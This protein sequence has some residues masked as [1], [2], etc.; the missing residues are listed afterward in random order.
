MPAMRCASLSLLALSLL[1]SGPALA[2]DTPELRASYNLY[3]AGF[4][5][6]D[7]DA[8]FGVGPHSYQLRLAY[9]TTGVISLFHYGHQLNTVVGT[10]EGGRPEP[11]EFQAVGVWQ[12]EDKVTLI[13]YL[14][15]QPLIRS[16]IPSQAKEREPVPLSLQQ[17]SV[18]SLSAVAL[19]I[20]RV[21]ETGRCDASAHMFDG[22]RA[23]EI[24]AHTV[25]EETLAPDD[26][27]IFSGKT[28]RC[29]FI[30]QM[31]AGF[32]YE[33]T[34]ASDRRPLHGTAWLARMAPGEPPVPVRLQFETHWFGD[35]T[36]YLV[37]FG[38]APS[39][40]VAAH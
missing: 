3:A 33:D 8:A 14:H 4:H 17:N 19:L 7:L 21:T 40:E 6:M 39:T 16:L 38:P 34:S 31:L 32:L 25:G 27:S 9:H 29:D 15:G 10:W 36:M 2:Q 11:R 37:Q 22:N 13:D 24:T 28:L 30:G 12:G 26:H 1:I 20:R 18:D 35:A 5:V 23:S